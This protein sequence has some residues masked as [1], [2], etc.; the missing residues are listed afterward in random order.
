M[1]KLPNFLTFSLLIF[2]IFV[3]QL[4]SSSFTPID[5]YLINC[6]SNFPAISDSYNRNFVGDESPSSDSLKLSATRTI[7]LTESTPSGDLYNSVRI[8]TEPSSYSFKINQKGAHLVRLHFHRLNFETFDGK[9]ANFHVLADDYL[10]LNDFSLLG[11]R[12]DVEIREFVLWVD[13]DELELSFVPVEKANFGFISAIEVISAPKDLILDIAQVV[14]SNGVTKINGLNKN[15]FETVFRVNVGGPKITPFNDTLW[16]T[17]VSDDE[18]VKSSGESKEVRFSGRIKYQFGGASREVAPDHVY[19]SARVISASDSSNSRYNLTWTFPVV[20]G[21][22]YLVR[23][24]FCD[25]VSRTLGSLYFNVYVNRILAYENLDLSTITN[26]LASPYY[27][28]FVVDG[29]NDG[30]ISVSVGNSA[31]GGNAILNGVEV[32]KMSN[33]VKS[34]DGMISA[35]SVL[36]SCHGENVGF[37]FI[38]VLAIGVLLAVSLLLRKILVTVQ[39]SVAWSRLPTDVSEVALKSSYH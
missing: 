6:G 8:F 9:N 7:P 32:F 37:P 20:G 36:R 13:S 16:R 30:V 28:D 4:V 1:A 2:T 33:A 15:G 14:N 10:L 19:G 21:Y 25:I 38:F 5:H 31:L 17:W 27:A 22:K 34:F 35:E 12:N 18:F 3:L 29:G 11:M 24:H 26:S 23:T 39:D